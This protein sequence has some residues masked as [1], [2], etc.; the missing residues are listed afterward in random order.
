MPLEA[1]VALVPTSSSCC[2]QEDQHKQKT[3]RQRNQ[4]EL[5]GP[6][7]SSQ[8]KLGGIGGRSDR[9]IALLH[10]ARAKQK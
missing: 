1:G 3:D 6:S 10:Q 9:A 4:D 7:E 2:G 8:G 5:Q